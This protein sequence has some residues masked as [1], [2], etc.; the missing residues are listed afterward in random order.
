MIE[1]WNF[2]GIDFLALCFCESA[3]CCGF[4]AL[5]SQRPKMLTNHTLIL[6]ALSELED[7]GLAIDYRPCDLGASGNLMSLSSIRCL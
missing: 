4:A 5:Y 7:F 6:F 3:L 1:I 2:P